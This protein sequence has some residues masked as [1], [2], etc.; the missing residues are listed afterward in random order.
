LGTDFVSTVAALSWVCLTR[1]AL[2]FFRGFFISSLLSGPVYYSRGPENGTQVFFHLWVRETV[3]K[4]V[5]VDG[6]TA[7]DELPARRQ[8][9]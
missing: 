7:R 1:G 9:V 5:R 6:R 8:R 4:D 3:L 2:R